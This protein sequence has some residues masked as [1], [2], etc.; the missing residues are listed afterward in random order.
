M[1]VILCYAISVVIHERRHRIIYC[2]TQR[3]MYACFVIINCYQDYYSLY[4]Y[5]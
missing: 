5:H 2:Y 1:M 4:F 3:V